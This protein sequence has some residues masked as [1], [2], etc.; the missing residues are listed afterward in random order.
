MAYEAGDAAAALAHITRA[1]E[2]ARD[3]LGPHH[4]L[5]RETAEKKAALTP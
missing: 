5:T 3:T 1:H 2:I 4:P